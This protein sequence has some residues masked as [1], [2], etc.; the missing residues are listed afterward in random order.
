M[1]MVGE[2]D[3]RNF[4]KVDPVVTNF[5]RLI[6]EFNITQLESAGSAGTQ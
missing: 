5:V 1:L 2:H 3:F 6:T 4:C